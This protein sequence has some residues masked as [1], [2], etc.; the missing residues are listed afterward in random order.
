MEKKKKRLSSWL[1]AVLSIFLTCLFPCVF[2]FAQNAGEANAVDMLPF[3]GLFLGTA[4]VGMGICCLILRN[5]SRAAFLTDLAMLVVMNFGLLSGGVE[6]L[7]PWFYSRYQL[8]ILTLLLLGILVLLLWKKPNMS[9]GCIILAVTFGT[10]TL[11]NFLM[12]IPK[13]LAVSSTAKDAVVRMEDV[14]GPA[15]DTTFAGEKR[16]VY[17]FFF[18]E[19]GGDENLMT[20]FGYDN[21]SFYEELEA[22]GFGVSRSSYNTESC[23]TDTL[24]PNLLNLDYVT[25]D[26]I[27]EKTRRLYCENPVL[28]QLFHSNGYQINLINHRASLIPTGTTVL[29]EGQIEDN[30]SEYL[31]ENSLFSK[32]SFINDRIEYMLFKSYRDN[33]TGPIENCFEK[34]VNCTDYVDGPTLTV[35]YIQSPHAPFIY[36][37]DGSHRENLATAWYWKDTTLYPNQLQ[38]LNTIILEAI[39][40]IQ[41]VDPTGVIIL[42][43]DHGARVP[44]HMVEQFGGP[45]FD[46]EK[47]TPVMQSVLFCAC[48]PGEEIDVEGMTGINGTRTALNAAF[49]L[50]LPEIPPAEG[51]VLPEMYNAKES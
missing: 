30:I 39:D 23:W 21:S 51:Y 5:V 41:K 8:V 26:S 16:N 34:L 27:P 3:L 37:A 32:I 50:S 31:L 47:E 49:G 18:D 42:L 20:Y 13:L 17:Y 11:V 12:A 44:L 7:L 38:Y 36:N 40:N 24:A 46:A 25:D 2:V 9:A 4:L 6:K 15:E 33:Y 43:S 19:Y 28:Y 14:L 10:L 29:T 1:P 35:S 45:R 48:V 22:R